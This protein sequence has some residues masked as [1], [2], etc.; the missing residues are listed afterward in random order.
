MKTENTTPYLII[1]IIILVLIIFLKDC[2]GKDD[3]SEVDIETVYLYK[4]DSIYKEKYF[5]LKKEFD[6]K[7]PPKEV[8]I[9][10]PGLTKIDT[11][12]IV[13]NDIIFYIEGLEESIRV[14][15]QFLAQYPHNHKLIEFNLKRDSLDITTLDKEANMVTKKYP[16]YLNHFK[17]R[18][19]KNELS[20]DEISYKENKDK[21]KWDELYFNYGFRVESSKHN[22][23]FEYNLRP[24]RFKV[25]LE[26]NFTI[27]QNPKLYINAKIGYRLF[28]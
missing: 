18:W 27:E 6:N 10:K 25:D 16:L 21:L 14:S 13:P 7:T 11:M 2:K 4:T 12:Y 15:K 9:W 22:L 23:G 19:V 8:V 17:Y 3:D 28:K 20:H 1:T 24:G 5:K 26:S